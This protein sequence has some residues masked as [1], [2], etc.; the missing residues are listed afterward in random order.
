M[1]KIAVAGGT[2]NVA[3]EILRVAIA[4]GKH[5]ITIFTRSQP[6]KPSPDVSYKTVDY[7]DRASLTKA[8]GGFDV[9]LSFL[10][11]HLDTDCT[12]QK[13]LIH[14]SM[15]AGVK[16]FAPSEWGIKN[17]SGVPPYAN[18]DEIARYLAELKNK[19]ELGGMQYCLFQPSIFMD[20]FAHP[21]SLSPEL[22]TWPFFVDYEN[23]RAMVLDDGDQPMVL[24][25][26]ADDSAMLARAL[27][28]PEAWPAVGGIR[29]CRTT[30]NEL[31]ALG[32]KIR[33]GE[34]KIE[35]V[36]GEDIKKGVFST[37]W[38]PQVSHPVIPDADREQFSKDFVVM[39]FQG[40]LNGS[41]DVTDEWNGRCPDY[42]FTGLEDYLT[43]AWEGKA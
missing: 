26:I 8:L 15:A 2:G 43:K 1:V 7:H 3:T 10:V 14:A 36:R 24:T 28:D 29:G 12:V 22:I 41:W 40:I 6:S 32:K 11:V 13:N 35:H 16:R 37:S 39:F 31:V 30:I 42:R 5:E 25:A 21:Y 4:S 23:R 38:V 33:G 18:K 17:N 9:C 34:W 27:E 19:G 20:Y